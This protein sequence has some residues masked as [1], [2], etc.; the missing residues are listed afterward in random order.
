MEDQRDALAGK[1]RK[2]PAFA[3]YHFL[4]Q[5]VI[6]N[7]TWKTQFLTFMGLKKMIQLWPLQIFLETLSIYIHL[8]MEEEEF[9]A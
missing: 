8:K 2:S 6:L 7:D 9:V 1:C 5:P 3:G 4:H